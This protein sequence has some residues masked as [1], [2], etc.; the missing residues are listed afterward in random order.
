[1]RA[2]GSPGVVQQELRSRHTFRKLLPH[3]VSL[4]REMQEGNRDA[5]GLSEECLECLTASCRGH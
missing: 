3:L 2:E 4:P 1:M 5:R